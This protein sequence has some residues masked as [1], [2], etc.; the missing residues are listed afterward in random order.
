MRNHDVRNLQPNRMRRALLAAVP[1]LG[2]GTLVRAQQAP[3]IR[4]NKLHNFEIR[5][6]DPAR[7]VAFYQELFGMPIQARQ[8][9]RYMMK[10]GD[11]NQFMAIRRV[12]AGESPAITYIGYTVEDYDLATQQQALAAL[13]Y[14]TI[15]PP[16]PQTP[17][18]ENAMHTWV[19]MRGDTPELFFADPRGLIVQLSDAS[20]CGGSGPL[21]A[22]CPAPEAAAPGL[23][24]LQ[25]LNH[26][27]AFVSD[28]AGANTY[29]QEIFGLKV[30]AYQGPGSPVTGIGDG[31]QFVMYAGGPAQDGQKVP[32]NLHHGSFNIYDFDVETVLGKLTAHG[33][34]ARP[35]GAQAGP[36]MH[37]ISLRQPERGG[38]EGGTPELYFTD[39]DG[40]L[41]QMQDVTYCGGGGYLG[42]ECLA[43]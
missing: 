14:T 39:P 35:D 23:F 8:G 28:G 21:G 43:G 18:I 25:E 9:D 3:T 32:A 17:G 40:I 26:F 20:Y 30:Q 41:L 12:E 38:V 1:A 11:T 15:D 2:L 37:Y 4:V 34:T 5:V 33:L 6:S 10:V 13:G 36:L 7:S 42:S 29:Y 24:R 19:R 27:T 31:H 22:E 16:A